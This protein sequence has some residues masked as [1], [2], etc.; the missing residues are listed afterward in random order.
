MEDI[1]LDHSKFLVRHSIFGLRDLACGPWPPVVCSSTISF[2]LKHHLRHHKAF[3]SER[4]IPRISRERH[5]EQLKPLDKRDVVHPLCEA[6]EIPHLP[7]EPAEERSHSLVPVIAGS[8][9][10]K[11]RVAKRKYSP[12]PNSTP[13]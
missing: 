8:T 6:V 11:E 5:L 4:E 9:V 12:E 1:K 10:E 13:G 3:Q 2:S 7:E